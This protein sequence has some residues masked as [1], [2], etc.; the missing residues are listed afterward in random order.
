VRG[1]EWSGDN[2]ASWSIDIIADLAVLPE[3]LRI[4]VLGSRKKMLFVEGT[5]TG[6]SLD[7]P[8]YS[9]LFPQVSVIAKESCKDVHR[10]VTGM[11][12]TR[13]EHHASAFGIVDQDGMDA[14]RVADLKAQG[15]FPLPMFAVESLY[16]CGD[17]LAAVAEQQAATLGDDPAT[18]VLAARRQALQA[19]SEESL[20]HF[21][22][23]SAERKLRDQLQFAV[24]TRKEI[25]AGS[26]IEIAFESPYPAEL[27]K[28]RALV[29]AGSF[30]A[31]IKGYPVRESQVFTALAK[32]LRFQDRSDY[33]RAALARVTASESLRQKMRDSL[34]DVSALLC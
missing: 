19:I 2:V 31:I 18:L 11:V 7:H 26:R 32:G 10:C 24:P 1:C 17:V 8:I 30:D 21:A 3:E 9:L 13:S 23:R 25:V 14:V 12:A 34:G 4:D 27:A 33:E 28:L 22:S 15:I 16:Y 6:R 29:D 20:A 5:A